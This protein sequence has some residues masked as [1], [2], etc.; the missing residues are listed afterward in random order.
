MPVSQQK[1]LQLASLP[2]VCGPGT[3]C[4]GNPGR[5]R[6]ADDE[7]AGRAPATG[8][9]L[10]PAAKFQPGRNISR[11]VYNPAEEAVSSKPQHHTLDTTTL[12]VNTAVLIH[13]GK[14][15]SYFILLTF[16]SGGSTETLAGN[17]RG[18]LLHKVLEV[19]LRATLQTSDGCLIQGKGTLNSAVL[20]FAPNGRTL[21]YMIVTSLESSSWNLLGLE[22]S[23]KCLFS[24]NKSPIVS[25]PPCFISGLPE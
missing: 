12:A 19:L 11:G 3:V 15:H 5:F 9:A 23:G 1:W 25:E 14:S 7:Q 13:S 22:H 10:R 2:E 17:R 18:C 6:Q 8:K 16:L 24:I 4:S 20:A 21:G